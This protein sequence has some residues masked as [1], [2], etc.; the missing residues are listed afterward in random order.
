MAIWIGV[1]SQPGWRNDGIQL[2]IY[3]SHI[4]S[5]GNGIVRQRNNNS[6]DYGDTTKSR[7]PVNQQRNNYQRNNGY[8][9]KVH[10]NGYRTAYRHSDDSYRD[11]Y[12]PEV[13]RRP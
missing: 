10:M 12:Y 3:S 9:T 4:D 8:Q 11:S 2:N 1:L 7:Y 5:T 13:S 6:K